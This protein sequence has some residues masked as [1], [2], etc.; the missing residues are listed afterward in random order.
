MKKS[1]KLSENRTHHSGEWNC[2]QML[3]QSWN[4]KKC[5]NP[6]IKIWTPLCSIFAVTMKVSRKRPWVWQ[7]CF[8]STSYVR[9]FSNIFQKRLSTQNL[10]TLGLTALVQKWNGT[11]NSSK[12][13]LKGRGK[14]GR[15]YWVYGVLLCGNI[16][17]RGDQIA[18]ARI[19]CL[20]LRSQFSGLG[21]CNYLRW[22]MQQL[23][24][25][26]FC[27]LFKQ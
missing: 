16:V 27:L 12:S 26:H 10:E 11:V 17:H 19:P 8:W 13:Y 1:L 7:I 22:V 20:N 23:A 5:G 9:G 4:A 3:H 18:A 21:F 25:L 6:L 14:Q 15:P 2:V 24:I